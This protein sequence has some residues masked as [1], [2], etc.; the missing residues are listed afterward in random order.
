MINASVRPIHFED[1]GGVEF[2]RLVF[3][4]HLRAGW[5]DLAWY[6]QTGSDLG[7]DITGTQLF[8]GQPNQRTVVQCVNRG[9]LTLSKAVHDMTAAAKAPTGKP[10]AFK[11]ICRSP[12]S[13]KMRDKISDAAAQLGVGHVTIWSGTEFEEEL[14]LRAQH[15]L[16]R[17][18]DG[19]QFPDSAD[20]LRRF[21]DDF[22]TM[23]DDE[24]LGMMAAVFERPAF[25]TP[26]VVESNLP[27]FQEALEDTVR[28]LNTGIWQTREGVEIRRIPSVHNLSQARNRLGI[29]QVVREV[30]EIRRVFKRNLARG[31]I[32]PCGC[33]SPTCP[34][35]M[36]NQSAARDLDDARDQA[37]RTFKSLYSAFDVRVG[38]AWDGF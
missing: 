8:D 1:F 15:L 32:R 38:G 14:R 20:E 33:G 16:Q 30:D 12:V 35:F 7:R 11:F 5:V 36:V 18:I 24:M 37:L 21:V 28:A 2:E 3:A 4:F 23:S 19:V 31:D 27:A 13:A 25:R 6:G 22:P 9:A 10:D 17:F 26:F 34:T 29:A